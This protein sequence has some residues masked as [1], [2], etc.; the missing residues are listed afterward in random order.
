MILVWN[1]AKSFNRHLEN[2]RAFRR[3]HKAGVE[4]PGNLLRDMPALRDIQPGGNAGGSFSCGGMV[5]VPIWKITL[6]RNMRN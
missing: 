6:D 4:Y 5:A 3:S 2:M 1:D